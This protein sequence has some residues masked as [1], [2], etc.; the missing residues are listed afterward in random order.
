MGD[1]FV[2]GESEAIVDTGKLLE[3]K[4]QNKIVNVTGNKIINVHFLG[5]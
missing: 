3:C 5:W 2:N 1:D 4:G